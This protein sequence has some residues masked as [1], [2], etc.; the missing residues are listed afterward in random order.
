MTSP[1]AIYRQIP[2]TDEISATHKILKREVVLMGRKE[3]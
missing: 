3:R 2:C 1:N